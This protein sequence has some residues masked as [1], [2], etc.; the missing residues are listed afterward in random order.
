[1]AVELAA[2]LAGARARGVR[3]AVPNL[4]L[5]LKAYADPYVPN[6]P[7]YPSQWFFDNLNME[8]AWGLSRGAASTGIVIVDTGCDGLHV[9]LIDKLD[10]GRDVI[11]QDDDPSPDPAHPGAAHG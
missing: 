4:Y 1:D 8:E 10:P 3:E 9:D 2:R 7:Q 5:R 6:D 11:D